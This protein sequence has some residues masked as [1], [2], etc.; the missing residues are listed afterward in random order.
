MQR[1]RCDSLILLLCCLHGFNVFKKI[2][3]RHLRQNEPCGMEGCFEESG[4]AEVRT[5]RFSSLL[6]PRDQACRR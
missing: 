5:F 6:Q 3:N 4:E 1:E 2:F